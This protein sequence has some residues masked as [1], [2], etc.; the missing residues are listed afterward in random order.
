MAVGRRGGRSDVH[1]EVSFPQGSECGPDGTRRG[2]PGPGLESAAPCC[3]SRRR[4]SR[5]VIALGPAACGRL[6]TQHIKVQNIII[7]GYFNLKFVMFSEVKLKGHR[8]TLTTG[9]KRMVQWKDVK[10][11][12][13]CNPL[14]A[15]LQFPVC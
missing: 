13:F 9:M 4:G 15:H 12:S 1:R 7:Q 14:L 5:R 2:R 6:V 11:E 3:V 10:H 8:D